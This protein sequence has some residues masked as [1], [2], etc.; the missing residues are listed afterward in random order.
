MN[1]EGADQDRSPGPDHPSI[2]VAIVSICGPAHLSR[3]LDALRD[4]DVATP[5]DVV[6][7]YDPGLHGIEELAPQYPEARIFSNV[8]QRTPLELASRA[9]A[10][11]GGDVVL[12]TEDHCVPDPHW[13][14]RLSGALAPGEAAV[15]G[16]VATDPTASA[17]DFAF[18]FVDFFRYAPPVV[19][20]PSPSLTVCNVAYRRQALLDLRDLWSDIFHETAVNSAIRDRHGPLRLI[21]DAPVSMRRHVRFGDA[22]YE[23]Y[24]FGR[25]F[26]CTRLEFEPPG[27]RL[28]YTVASP[29]LPALILSRMIR[30]VIRAPRL[31]WPFT[32]ALFHLIVLIGAWSWGEW[33]G[34]LT[35]K[36]PARLT[37]AQEEPVP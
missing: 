12:L 19:P 16:S 29:A 25:L 5:F 7:A 13:V 4:Q 21:A 9:V 28:L 17:L 33:L 3:C 34:Y 22:V 24:A 27:R 1:A 26:G 10:A 31:R 37:V 36:R 11:S 30:K 18:Y 6:V 20:G 2:T 15:G 35:R 14:S 8:G 32:R 23:R